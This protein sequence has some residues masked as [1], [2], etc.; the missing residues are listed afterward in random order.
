MMS[1][2]PSQLA[3]HIGLVAPLYNGSAAKEGFCF[4]SSCT[5]LAR[6]DRMASRKLLCCLAWWLPI[7]INN[8]DKRCDNTERLAFTSAYAQRDYEHCAEDPALGQSSSHLL[9]VQEHARVHRGP[10]ASPL[11]SLPGSEQSASAE[12]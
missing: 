12:D 9:L 3:R 8:G 1:R 11:H 4:K 5:S 6:F 10:N 2:W 7:I